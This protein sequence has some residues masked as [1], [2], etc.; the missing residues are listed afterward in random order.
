MARWNFEHNGNHYTFDG[1]HDL[2]LSSLRKIKE[3]Y[4]ELGSYLRFLNGL[5]EGDPNAFA[6]MIWIGRR[7]AGEANAPEPQGMED[8]ALGEFYD[9]LEVVPDKVDETPD[10]LDGQSEAG[11]IPS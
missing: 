6:C 9:S 7:K 1:N 11:T 5:G 2:T 8:F 10:P 4:P 3:W